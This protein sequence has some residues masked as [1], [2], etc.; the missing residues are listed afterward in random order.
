MRGLSSWSVM[1]TVT[2]KSVFEET[3]VEPVDELSIIYNF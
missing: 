2:I 1:V 3:V